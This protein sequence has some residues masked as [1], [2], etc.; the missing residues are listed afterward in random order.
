[1]V[2]FPPTEIGHTV[3]KFKDSVSQ[4]NFIWRLHFDIEYQITTA[5]ATFK[6]KKA[7][8]EIKSGVFKITNSTVKYSMQKRMHKLKPASATSG[9]SPGQSHEQCIKVYVGCEKL[10]PLSL[11]YS[12]VHN[13]LHAARTDGKQNS[14]PEAV[15]L[16]PQF[17][18]A[19]FYLPAPDFESAPSWKSESQ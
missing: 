3:K 17:V 14:A 11:Y 19:V 10:I 1:L 12:S 9:R 5:I 15:C 16:L 4:C 18:P 13:I 2:V 6:G 7:L 8:H